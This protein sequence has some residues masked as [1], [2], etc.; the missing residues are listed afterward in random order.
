MDADRDSA[1]RGLGRGG[2]NHG[3]LADQTFLGPAR[4]APGFTLY[5]LGGFPGMY[6]HSGYSA[7]VVGELWSV[8]DDALAGLDVFEGVP[9]GLYRRGPVALTSPAGTDAVQTYFPVLPPAPGLR[10]V[11][12]EWTEPPP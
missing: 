2:C 1:G 3:R 12:I 9:E 6:P 4:T 5:D 10:H 11:G 7:G 8:G